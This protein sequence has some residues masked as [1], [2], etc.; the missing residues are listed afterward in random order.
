MLKEKKDIKEILQTSFLSKGVYRFSKESCVAY[1]SSLRIFKKI[2]V[3]YGISHNDQLVLPVTQHIKG[4]SLLLGPPD[5]SFFRQCGKLSLGTY[6][7]TL[8]KLY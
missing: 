5:Y 8:P 1:N 4:T 3:H 7:H 6:V 2:Y